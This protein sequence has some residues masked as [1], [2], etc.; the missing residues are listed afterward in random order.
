MED[1]NLEEL[2]MLCLALKDIQSMGY[3]FL[4][5]NQENRIKL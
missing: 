5:L 4:K 1:N 3:F 2:E